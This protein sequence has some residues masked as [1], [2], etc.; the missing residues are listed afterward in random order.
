MKL[1]QLISDIVESVDKISSLKAEILIEKKIS[2]N[3][4]ACMSLNKKLDEEKQSLT[5]KIE[6]ALKKTL[7]E[8]E[9]MSYTYSVEYEEKPMNDYIDI[10]AQDSSG[11]WRTYRSTINT[12]FMVTSAMRELQENFPERRIRAVDSNGRLIDIL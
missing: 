10:Q 7:D 4:R 9:N 2:S 6:L 8:A 5:E 1:K 12:S 11:L 3:Y